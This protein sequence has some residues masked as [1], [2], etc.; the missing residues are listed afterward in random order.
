[1][2]VGGAV[3][4]LRSQWR[5]VIFSA[6][7]LFAGTG[8]DAQSNGWNVAVHSPVAWWETWTGADATRNSWSLYSGLT[9]APFGDIRKSGLRLRS[10]AG[11]GRYRYQGNLLINRQVEPTVFRGTVSF[12]EALAGFQL[13]WGPLTTN[14]SLATTWKCA[15]SCHSTR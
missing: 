13:N 5:C 7:I 3:L 2:R 9:I 12:A 8:V 1:M 15:A 14:C 4:R 10:V 6:S 11:Y